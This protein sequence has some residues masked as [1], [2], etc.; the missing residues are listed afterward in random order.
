MAMLDSIVIMQFVQRMDPAEHSGEKVILVLVCD[1]EA[2]KGLLPIEVNVSQLSSGTLASQDMG[3]P[4]QTLPTPPSSREDLAH[5]KD[6]ALESIPN[7]RRPTST[8]DLAR[9][10]TPHTGVSQSVFPVTPYDQLIYTPLNPAEIPRRVDSG[11]GFVP[12]HR[13]CILI[14]IVNPVSQY[15]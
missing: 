6:T 14:H 1:F 7:S 4:T 2:N 9:R 8:C 15:R 12:T 3:L 5:L 13:K 11:A 10:A